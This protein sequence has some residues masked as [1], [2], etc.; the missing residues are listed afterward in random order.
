MTNQTDSKK[1]IINYGLV[2]GVISVFIGLIQ[3]ALG[4]HLEQNWGIISVSFLSVIVLV[5]L[6]IKKFKDTNNGFLSWGQAV[7][8]GVGIAVISGLIGAFYQY[9]FVNFIEPDFIEL[10]AE[11]QE[12]MLLEQGYSEEQ[13]EM[14]LK[15]SKKFQGPLLTTAMSIIAAAIFGFIIAAIGGAIMNKTPQSTH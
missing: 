2:L 8:I 9:I 15:M 6:G 11:K 12:I 1:I 13:V 10:M 4:I 5:I 7:K 3:Y 14:S